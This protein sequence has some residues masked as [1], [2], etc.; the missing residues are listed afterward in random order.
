MTTAYADIHRDLIERCIAGNRIAQYELYKQYS[1]A[2]FN[3]CCRMLNNRHEAED[4]LQEAFAEAF[5]KLNTF[6]FESSFGAW[7]KRIVIN[8][9]INSL[10]KRRA[11]LVLKEDIVKYDS[12]DET[13]DV[14]EMEYEIKRIHEAIAMLPEGYR[15]VFTL[16]LF[17][18]YD[19]AQIAEML[20]VSEST[21]KT[22]YMRA[23]AKIKELLKSKMI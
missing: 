17:E 11:E 4:L 16:Y 10:K 6:R 20:G 8:K 22:Q 19:H 13:D 2:M 12:A 14:E 3:I 9:C 18:D 5:N 23:K 15:V 7:L 21:S 1:K